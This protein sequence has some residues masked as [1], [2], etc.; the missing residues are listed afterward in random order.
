MNNPFQT[1]LRNV[2]VGEGQLLVRL[3][4]LLMSLLVVAGVYNFVLFHGLSDSQSMDNAQLAR[5]LDRGE[6]FTTKFI[7]PYAL[8]QLKD[9]AQN[10]PLLTGGNGELFPASQFPDGSEK[11]LPDTYN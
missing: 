1:I 9:R 8:S 5:Q 3:I 10:Q 6:G 2:E 7:R 4:P 11:I